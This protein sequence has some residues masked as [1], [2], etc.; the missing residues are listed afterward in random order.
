MLCSVC[1][2]Q[3][4]YQE[5]STI[6]VSFYFCVEYVITNVSEKTAASVS[7]AENRSS[8]FRRTTMSTYLL[9]S[10]IR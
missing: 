8:I 6:L 9:H 7:F 4:I 2:T 1:T 5:R 10:V 3:N